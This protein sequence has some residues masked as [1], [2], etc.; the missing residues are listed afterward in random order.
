MKIHIFFFFFLFENYKIKKL[1]LKFVTSEFNFYLP[2][3][4]F[5]S[6]PSNQLEARKKDREKNNTLLVKEY[7]NEFDEK[8][9]ILEPIKD[10]E[11]VVQKR[12]KILSQ[13]Q[14]ILMMVNSENDSDVLDD[15]QNHLSKYAVLE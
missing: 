15:I 11:T 6:A 12:E 13:L 8:V 3:T 4:F 5:F 1:V 10:E 2:F 9:Y 14:A 7:L